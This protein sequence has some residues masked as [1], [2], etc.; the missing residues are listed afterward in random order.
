MS[1]FWRWRCERWPAAVNLVLVLT[2]DWRG[3]QREKFVDSVVKLYP[4]LKQNRA[5]LEFGYKVP[6]AFLSG[7]RAGPD[8]GAEHEC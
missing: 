3:L 2:L 6:H 7:W 4:Q 1:P 5:D 8:G